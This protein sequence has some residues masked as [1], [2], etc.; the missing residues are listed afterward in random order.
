[1]NASH[2]P[3]SSTSNALPRLL[4]WRAEPTRDPRLRFKLAVSLVLAC[5]LALFGWALYQPLNQT[6]TYVLILTPDEPIEFSFDDAIDAVDVPQ[7]MAA[8]NAMRI[9]AS[10]RDS[11]SASLI[12]SSGRSSLTQ[13][14][15]TIREL[16]NKTLNRQSTLI[17][18]ASGVLATDRT[19]PA[20]C[21]CSRD[22][23]HSGNALRIIPLVQMLQSIECRRVLLCVDANTPRKVLLKAPCSLAWKNVI[24]HVEAHLVDDK[25]TPLAVKLQLDSTELHQNQI[26]TSEIATALCEMLS[27]HRREGIATLQPPNRSSE[28]SIHEPS[29]SHQ[30]SRVWMVSANWP[31]ESHRDWPHRVS[32]VSHGRPLQNSE[33][34]SQA[35]L[36]DAN[37]KPPLDRDAEGFEAQLD[38][39][40]VEQLLDFSEQ[41]IDQWNLPKP[42]INCPLLCIPQPVNFRQF[43]P[44]AFHA[45]TSLHAQ[46]RCIQQ[47]APER[48]DRSFVHSFCRCLMHVDSGGPLPNDI[49]KWLQRL[50]NTMAQNFKKPSKSLTANA[51]LGS[52][53]LLPSHS[54]QS[55]VELLSQLVSLTMGSNS[56]R[57][58]ASWLN[59][60][61]DH[62]KEFDEILWTEQVLSQP[63]LAWS[64]QRSLIQ[65]RL[66]SERIAS[67][68][69]AQEW[70][71]ESLLQ[72]DQERV[73]AE[74]LVSD[75]HNSDWESIAEAKNREALV[76]YR[77]AIDQLAR[78]RQ[79]WLQ[80]A[81]LVT[82]SN[83]SRSRPVPLALKPLTDATG[84]VCDME[85][86]SDL[87]FQLLV[88][89]N[90]SLA[91]KWV[92]GINSLK[93]K[94][95]S[96]ACSREEIVQVSNEYVQLHNTQIEILQEWITRH[97]SELP[98]QSHFWI[99]VEQHWNKQLD[100]LTNLVQSANDPTHAIVAMNLDRCRS[101]LYGANTLD[102]QSIEQR[103]EQWA[104]LG[105]DLAISPLPC[106]S[107]SLG[108]TVDSKLNL[109]VDESSETKFQ[110][111][112]ASLSSP[113]M[114]EANFDAKDFSIQVDGLEIKNGVP[115]AVNQATQRMKHQLSVRRKRDLLNPY[116][117]LLQASQGASLRRG[118]IALDSP[119]R[120][121]V[122]LEWHNTLCSIPKMDSQRRIAEANNNRMG[123]VLFANQVNSVALTLTNSLPTS[124][125]LECHV[126]L[127]SNRG[128][129]PP[130]GTVSKEVAKRWRDAVVDTVL[131][132]SAKPVTLSEGQ[133]QTVVFPPSPWPPEQPPHSFDQLLVEIHNESQGT[134]QF[135][136]WSPQVLHP[137]QYIQASVQYN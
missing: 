104:G 23:T 61:S 41:I 89:W 75:R 47:L 18:Y 24:D 91:V 106:L 83:P 107:P 136:P 63:M 55:D 17:V 128:H 70:C 62:Q 56:S 117:I 32:S 29:Q 96:V 85:E 86:Q 5:S 124:T 50:P 44:F 133:S 6:R 99:F 16:L 39:A 20:L 90:R 118:L 119:D 13:P 114:L 100:Q 51:T 68:P 134:V 60:L 9:Q 1:M 11:H 15:D 76:M 135:E 108:L 37:P 110:I 112:N 59:T 30:R 111:V 122:S 95:S 33:P 97:S 54:L 25:S 130:V 45:I 113:V 87:L 46:L 4:S 109:A 132:A 2:T 66:L 98:K 123:S 102:I 126:L 137:R 12:P 125:T 120:P 34:K 43:N 38:L 49:P 115:I 72:A 26:A 21:E 35:V 57:E 71:K 3:H 28:N 42:A 88:P 93:A 129:K 103:V 10:V 40:S 19:E 94:L 36:E 27:E 64:L 92:G 8:A 31:F 48:L 22:A 7:W 81:D 131:V 79:R 58:L 78:V 67:D 80:Y 14:L 77:T 73:T 116:P 53:G 74:R 105:T 101:E 84:L 121:M 65:A 82:C 52:L 69:L 127:G